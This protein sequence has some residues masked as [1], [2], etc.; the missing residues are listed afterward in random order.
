VP[1]A[2]S[3][4]IIHR[5]TRIVVVAKDAGTLSAPAPGDALSLPEL[6]PGTLVVHRLDRGTSGVL[7]LARDREAAAVL[8]KQ[9]SR[10]TM[11]REYVALVSGVIPTDSGTMNKRV[12]DRRAVTH[13]EV[14]ERF[15]SVTKIALRLETG[16]KHQIRCHMA[17]LGH[18]VLG[19]DRYGGRAYVRLALHARLLG[20]DHPGTK[21]RVSFEAPVPDAIERPA[22]LAHHVDGR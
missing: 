15:S 3:F 2:P 21:R 16:R 7:V 9:L 18:P 14:L 22:D 13:W 19:D 11:E 4:A 17:E 10:H 1:E 12:D 5:D 20:F 6:I 8:A